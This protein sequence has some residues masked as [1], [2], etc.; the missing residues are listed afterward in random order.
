M[1]FC[2]EWESQLNKRN[3]KIAGSSEREV[4]KK[5]PVIMKFHHF[6]C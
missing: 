6:T 5:V 4:I 1:N 2:H 3:K